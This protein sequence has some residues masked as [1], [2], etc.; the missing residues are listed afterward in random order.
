M[1]SS[2]LVTMEVTVY[3]GQK[4]WD[5]AVTITASSLR[6]GVGIRD[7]LLWTTSLIQQINALEEKARA[8]DKPATKQLEQQLL[9]CQMMTYQNPF[10]SCTYERAVAGSFAL[11]DGTPGY[12]LEIRG[13]LEVGLDFEGVRSSLGLYGDAFDYLREYGLPIRL[14]APF[15][16][17]EV[18]RVDGFAATVVY[19]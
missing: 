14:V 1:R 13:P 10:V 16:V 12:I 15:T 3:R 2:E 8:A 6:S 7:P 9:A 18:V 11:S 19:P 5:P 17:D 4:W